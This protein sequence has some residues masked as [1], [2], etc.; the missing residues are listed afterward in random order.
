MKQGCAEQRMS[1]GP[2]RAPAEGNLRAKHKGVYSGGNIVP[3]S[4]HRA[5]QTGESRE[6]RSFRCGIVTANV[7]DYPQIWSGVEDQLA[8]PSIHV[9]DL[10]CS[11]N[12]V[13]EPG[14]GVATEDFNFGGFLRSRAQ[15]QKHHDQYRRNRR[16][17][18]QC[19][20]QLTL[21]RK[22]STA[23]GRRNP[24]VRVERGTDAILR[25]IF[26]RAL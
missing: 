15:T 8:V 1:K 24:P 7:R 16:S 13:V 23:S 4:R 14:Q 17:S 12:S 10:T 20:R 26:E 2:E 21:L 11:S 5:V 6:W 18:P 25:T 22:E 3:R 9:E 19:D